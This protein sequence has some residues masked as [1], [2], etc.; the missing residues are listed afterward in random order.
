MA[1]PSTTVAFGLPRAH[2]GDIAA[3][4]SRCFLLLIAAVVFLVD[5]HKA[6]ILNRR[7][8]A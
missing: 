8:D 4:V 1:D 6:E 3:V 7:E 2:H 5:N